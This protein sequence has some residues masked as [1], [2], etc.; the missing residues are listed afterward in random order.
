MTT[1]GFIYVIMCNAFPVEAWQDEEKAEARKAKLLN[2]L[3]HFVVRF[4]PEAAS[5][6]YIREQVLRQVHYHIHK[7]GL[8]T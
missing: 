8:N 7:I 4:A 6:E 5:T 1:A 3:E 2:D